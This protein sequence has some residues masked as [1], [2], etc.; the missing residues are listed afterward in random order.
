[1]EPVGLANTKISTD[2]YAQKSPRTLLNTLV[3]LE[4]FGPT[5]IAVHRA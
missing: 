3:N 2:N 5:S 1:M 4:S